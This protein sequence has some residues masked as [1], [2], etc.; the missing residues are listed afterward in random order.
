MPFKRSY[1]GVIALSKGCAAQSVKTF[2]AGDDFYNDKALFIVLSCDN[3][4]VF[5]GYGHGS[6]F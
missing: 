5:N 4:N 1:N 3:F 2:F 6:P